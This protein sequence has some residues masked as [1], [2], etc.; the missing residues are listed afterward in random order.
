MK[1]LVPVMA[2]IVGWSSAAGS[3]SPMTPAEAVVRALEVLCVTPPGRDVSMA[4]GF[5]YWGAF[6]EFAT[7]EGDLDVRPGRPCGMT[8][9]GAEAGADAV[10]AAIERWADGRGM[11]S[12][13]VVWRDHGARYDAGTVEWRIIPSAAADT[14]IVEITY[15]P[16]S[17]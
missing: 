15:W 12:S 8:Y 10:I 17:L 4:E 1:I 7:A 5:E 6:S 9:R 16:A 11:G 3:S 2:L 14:G 13:A